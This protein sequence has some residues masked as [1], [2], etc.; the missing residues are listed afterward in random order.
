[1]QPAWRIPGVGVMHPCID[2]VVIVST[3]SVGSLKTLLPL[4]ILERGFHS[5]EI[6]TY[7]GPHP[8]LRSRIVAVG[9]GNE[10]V[11]RLL[12]RHEHRLKRYW[13]TLVELAFDVRNCFV[14]DV[15]PGLLALIA[16]LDKRWQQRG[17]LHL[18]SKP[19]A[20]VSS[21]YLP[22]MPTIYYEERRSSVSMKCYGRRAKLPGRRFGACI[23][24]LE[25]TLKGKRALL[26]R[27]GGNQLTD[28]LAADL[29]AFLKRNLRLARV[30]HVA[31][32]KLFKVRRDR[33]RALPI[34]R[35]G[36]L[37]IFKQFK[38]PDYRA[39]RAAFLVLRVRAY[40]VSHGP[41]PAIADFDE[42]LHVCQESPAQ[43]R[44]YLR[45]L[46][47][48]GKPL[49]DYRINRCFRPVRLLPV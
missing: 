10:Q 9:A 37:P 31:V 34:S 30:D 16:R 28:L 20:R 17:H 39:G 44:G 8:H 48:R 22:G 7:R 38:D 26:R 13:I 3:A 24:R 18:M 6:L 35:G 19:G 5:F 14:E 32:G 27:L 21:G 29:N 36:A 47:Q 49:T 4:P 2:R 33:N 40:R 45:S 42:A 12:K 1:M 23:I 25:W 41:R 15:R 11:W 46:R 43:V